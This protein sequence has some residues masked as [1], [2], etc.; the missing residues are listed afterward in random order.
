MSKF[1]D[2]SAATSNALGKP[3]AFALA[4]TAVVI[5]ALA[6]PLLGFSEGW[7]LVINTVTTIITFL[8]VFLVHNSENHHAKAVQAK[9][10]ELIAVTSAASNQLIKAEDLTDKD[11]DEVRESPKEST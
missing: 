5:W 6:G 11:L 4:V 1:D 9:L 7:M 3:L 8:M 2:I 10:D